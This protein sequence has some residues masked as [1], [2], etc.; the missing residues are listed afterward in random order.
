MMVN[1]LYVPEALDD[2]LTKLGEGSP[3]ISRSVAKLLAR[4]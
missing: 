4:S 1:Y 3:R 2:N